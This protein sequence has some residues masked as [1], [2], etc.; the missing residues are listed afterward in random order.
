MKYWEIIAETQKSSIQRG[1][2]VGPSTLMGLTVWIVDAHREGTRFIVRTDEILTAL[3]ELERA[4][5][6][7]KVSFV[8]YWLRRKACAERKLTRFWNWKRRLSRRGAI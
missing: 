4:I 7:F 2:G 5:H 8:L 6:E 1:L 3:V